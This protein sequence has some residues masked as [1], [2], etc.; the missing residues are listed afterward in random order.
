MNDRPSV[1]FWVVSEERM[2]SD[3]GGFSINEPEIVKRSAAD[4]GARIIRFTS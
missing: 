2:S 1:Y 4:I 3:I